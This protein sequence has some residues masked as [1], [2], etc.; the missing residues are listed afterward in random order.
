[1]SGGASGHFIILE[2]SNPISLHIDK[3]LWAFFF[4]FLRFSVTLQSAGTKMSIRKYILSLWSL[5]T[6]PG[7]LVLIVLSL[8]IV[9]YHEIVAVSMSVTGSKM[10]S[11]YFFFHFHSYKTTNFP[12]QILAQPVISNFIS[13]EY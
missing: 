12:V 7:L 9:K 5:I 11:F 2:I 8:C 13:D 6:M 3:L 4:F 10:C 1:M